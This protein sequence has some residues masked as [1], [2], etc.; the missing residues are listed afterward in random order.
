MQA[1]SFLRGQTT[2]PKQK[3]DSSEPG[4]F[5]PF[6]TK[7]DQPPVILVISAISGRNIAKTMVPTT[8]AR[9][10]MSTGS[11]MEVSAVTALSTSSS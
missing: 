4:F 5:I 2:D 1:A 8:T 6:K 3:P 10:T 11:M 9:K 7:T